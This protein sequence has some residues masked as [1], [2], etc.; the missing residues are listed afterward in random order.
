[1]TATDKA[2]I[3]VSSSIFST[4][5]L[6]YSILIFLPYILI[7]PLSWSMTGVHNCTDKTGNRKT[8]CLYILNCFIVI[9]F[10]FVEYSGC[11]N[12][13]YAQQV[14]Y[15]AGYLFKC[16]KEEEIQWQHYIKMF[17]Y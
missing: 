16:L 9:S 4:C 15:F 14:A 10:M 5:L 8:I 3:P 12:I 6:K 11:G 1:M 13:L 2:G 17:L 7:D